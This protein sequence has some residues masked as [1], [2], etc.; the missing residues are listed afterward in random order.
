MTGIVELKVSNANVSFSLTL[1]RNITVLTGE[2]ATGKTTLIG[3]LR[4]YE[5]IG[6]SSGISLQCP[7][8]CRVLTNTD[9]EYR[10]EAMKD[11]VVF[12]DEGNAFV[13][14]QAFARAICGSSNYYVIVTRENLYQLPY[15]VKSI[16]KL[17]TTSK[18][19]K[20]YVKS[21]PQYDRL[22]TP[23]F[24]GTD[25]I[26][27]EDSNSGNELFTR[28]AGENGISCSSAQGKSNVF[29]AVSAHL[30]ERML[31]VADGAAFGAELEKLYSLAQA[32]PKK[33]AL[34][35]PESFEWLIL[36]SGILRGK[37][38]LDILK[39]PADFIDSSLYFSWEQYFTDLLVR[40]TKDT[41]LH[42]SKQ[43]L[44]PVYLQDGN[45]AKILSAMALSDNNESGTDKKKH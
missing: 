27:T 16:L 39:N 30:G 23:S 9:W 24:S 34:Y 6:S 4:D 14:S 28:I 11:C 13:K 45:V 10:L 25:R 40:L 20:T 33:I 38:P 22:E 36:K 42:Y 3:L 26:I 35:L 41:V 8:K 19:K 43:R 29:S 44:N 15:S 21:Y 5:E 32:H 1:E 18:R 2:S 12:L 37:T 31:V 17:K 7:Q